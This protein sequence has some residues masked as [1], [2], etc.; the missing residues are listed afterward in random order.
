MP[1]D[2]ALRVN[3]FTISRAAERLREAFAKPA[4]RRKF[5]EQ[6]LATTADIDIATARG[7]EKEWHGRIVARRAGRIWSNAFSDQPPG[8]ESGARGSPRWRKSAGYSQQTFAL[9]I[10]VILDGKSGSVGGFAATIL[11]AKAAKTACRRSGAD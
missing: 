9:W 11:N 3:E 8:G 7:L 6:G 4:G 2:A 1:F 10:G 5:T